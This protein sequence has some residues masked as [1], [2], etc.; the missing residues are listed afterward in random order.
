VAGFKEDRLMRYR[1]LT[2]LAS[3]IISGC[4][5][6]QPLKVDEAPKPVVYDSLIYTRDPGPLLKV[7]FFSA[8]DI[9]C[10]ARNV[11]Y[12][13]GAEPLEGKV[14]VAVV[15]INRT[16]DVRFNAK[17]VC[18]VVH[19]RSGGKGRPITCQFSWTCGSKSAIKKDDPKWIASREVAENI[20]R[21]DYGELSYKYRKALYFHAIAVRPAWAHTKRVVARIGGHIF[22]E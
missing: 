15:T 4:I 3:L 18:G 12:E 20:A 14:A 7:P 6:N 22:Y 17:T 9:E 11:Y 1:S 19:A 5:S 16:Q 13:S 10:L 8:K 21:G 2:L